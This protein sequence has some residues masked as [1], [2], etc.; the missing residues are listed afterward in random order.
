[1]RQQLRSFPILCTHVA[2]AGAKHEKTE[3][4]GT[5][6]VT[7][8][9][10]I[11]T[12]VAT[13]ALGIGSASAADLAARP[14]TK[15]PPPVASVYNWTGFYVGVNGGWV[16]SNNGS[17]SNVG[18]DTGL[19]GLGTAVNVGLIPFAATGFNNSGGM[20]GGTVGYNW[21]VAPSWVVG[22]EGDIDWVSAKRTVN[23]GFITV[24]GFVPVATSY[25][26]ELDWLATFRGRVGFLATPAL[27]L[28]ATGGGAAGEVKIGNQF[29]C[30]TCA[31]PSS[32]QAGTVGTNDT[33]AV[34]WTVGAGFEWKFAPAWS[35]KAEYLY[36]DLGNHSSA[37][38]YTYGANTSSL[39]SS[40]HDTFNVARVGVNY[41]FGAPVVAKY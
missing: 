3:A 24:P 21:Q 12:I 27:L 10:F 38:T 35:M 37:I 20:V 34:G 26:R 30:P 11:A 22:F 19:G 8:S 4:E 2:L 5:T 16:G 6:N 41:A 1:M 36:V 33:T 32:T 31:P 9:K 39:T 23:T 15:A 14:Y 7:L 29:I 17:L 18:T 40:V 25:T 28:Y 13:S